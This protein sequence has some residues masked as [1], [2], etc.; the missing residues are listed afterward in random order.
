MVNTVSLKRR[1][2][3]SRVFRQGKY[4]AGQYLTV[5]V[6]PNRLG[7]NRLA[8]SQVRHF[9]NSVQRNRAKRLSRE[10]YT[11]LEGSLVTGI[12]LVIVARACRVKPDFHTVGAEMKYLFNKLNLFAEGP[13]ED[14]VPQDDPVLPDASV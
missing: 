8:V 9:G 12:D 7:Y 6:R 2:D 14:A 11:R 1:N 10:N 13:R 5:Y 3:I 4:R